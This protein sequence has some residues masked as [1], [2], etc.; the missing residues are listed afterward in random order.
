[1]NFSA[2]S[3]GHF[4]VTLL[5]AFTQQKLSTN[6][7]QLKL[8][9]ST[10]Q[11]LVFLIAHNCLKRFANVNFPKPRRKESCSGRIVHILLQHDF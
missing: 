11:Q 4:Q 1:M 5:L 6:I 9:I 3:K 8:R 7:T 10:K 2:S